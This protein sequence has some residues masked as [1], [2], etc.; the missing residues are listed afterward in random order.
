VAFP[1]LLQSTA[2]TNTLLGSPGHPTTQSATVSPS[3]SDATKNGRLVS[4]DVFR[5]L[6][7]AGM[8]L[9]TNPGLW[10]AVYWPLLHA[11][12]NGWT[13]ADMIFPSFL[14]AVGIAMTLSFRTRMER[15]DTRAKLIWHVIRRSVIIF[16]IGLALN[17]FPQFDLHTLRIPGILQRIA[18]CYLC[19][20]L[21]YLYVAV[22]RE[23]SDG[24]AT[25]ARM[26][27]TVISGTIIAILIG[28]WLLLMLVPVPG[29]GPGRLDSLGNLGAYID[30][31]LLGTRHLWQWGVTPSYGVTYDPEG[32]LST[33]PAI[34]TLLMGILVGGVAGR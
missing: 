17:A 25:R 33:V 34:A 27:A 28:Y 14:V 21:L 1:K 22:G 19:G 24:L 13:P 29:F 3:P 20:S 23:R 31:S 11:D 5:G 15:G 10:S 32:L 16:V 2:P 12:W 4:L 7:I 8:I 30:R 9:V 6:T 26:R 18:L